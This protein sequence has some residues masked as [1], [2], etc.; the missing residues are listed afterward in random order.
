MIEPVRLSE[1]RLAFAL[2]RGAGRITLRSN[3]FVPAHTRPE[4][5]DPRELGLCVARLQIDG[6]EIPLGREACLGEG[7]REAEY[8]N[9]TFVRR[10]T[11]GAAD[12]PLGVRFVIVDLGGRGY[13]WRAP[14]T[15]PFAVRA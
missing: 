3:V 11:N 6:D 4:N 8:Q 12:L 2:P 7:W 13:Y 14:E 9:E 5:S 15:P 1:T 10:W